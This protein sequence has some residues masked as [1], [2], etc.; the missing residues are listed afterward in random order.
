MMLAELPLSDAGMIALCLLAAA[1]CFLLEVCTPSFG[2][3]AFLGLASFAGA[4][5]FGFRINMF[6]GMMVILGCLIVTPIYLYF[7]VKLLP[8][9]PLGKRLFLRAAPDATNDAAPESAI[10]AS[11][12][13]KTGV[14]ETLLRPSGV[15]KIEGRR[16]DAL[17][18]HGM[19]E[20]G[21]SIRILRAGGTD[22]VVTRIE[23]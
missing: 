16:Y 15:V 5:V 10:L 19:I 9:T 8:K 1:V 3:L 21:E 20:K 6:V 22:V 13:G 18:E 14:A 17:A 12:V 7:L 23:S 2:V 4:V 11:L